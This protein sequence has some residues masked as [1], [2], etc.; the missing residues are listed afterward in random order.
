[1]PKF[2]FGDPANDVKLLRAVLSGFTGGEAPSVMDR[3]AS[4]SYSNGDNASFGVDVLANAI[5]ATGALKMLAGIAKAP[6]GLPRLLRGHSAE[7]ILA[8]PAVVR[9]VQPLSD[10]FYAQMRDMVATHTVMVLIF[11][12]R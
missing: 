12:P 9:K 2:V 8:D 3:E 7:S 1:M 6:R 5:P 11:D 4:R 10:D